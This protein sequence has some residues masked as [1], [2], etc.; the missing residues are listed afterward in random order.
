MIAVAGAASHLGWRQIPERNNI[1]IGQALTFDAKVVNCVAKPIIRGKPV[2]GVQNVSI[3]RQGSDCGTMI[4]HRKGIYE[5]HTPRSD[6][7][8]RSILGLQV[9]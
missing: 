5:E 8:G 7:G 1:V 6:L 3:Q 4:G 9:V 2:F